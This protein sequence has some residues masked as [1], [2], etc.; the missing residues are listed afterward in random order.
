MERHKVS[1]VPQAVRLRG[2]MSACSGVLLL[3]LPVFL[4]I[5]QG[6]SVPAADGLG[7]SIFNQRIPHACPSADANGQRVYSHGIFP[8]MFINLSKTER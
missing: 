4:A 3:L 8:N 2:L 1:L 5:S 6:A 7:R